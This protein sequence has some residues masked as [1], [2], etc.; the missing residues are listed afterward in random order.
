MVGKGRQG[1]GSSTD[2]SIYCAPSQL[3]DEKVTRSV[4]SDTCLECGNWGMARLLGV[5]LVTLLVLG[6]ALGTLS[7]LYW[8]AKRD[9]SAL[10]GDNEQLNRRMLESVSETKT[11]RYKKSLVESDLDKLHKD[12]T[13][14]DKKISE[15]THQGTDLGGQLVRAVSCKVQVQSGASQP[16]SLKLQINQIVP[17]VVAILAHRI[18]FYQTT[19]QTATNST[20][21][22]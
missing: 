10:Q 7:F 3:A 22:Y 12:L 11:F 21:R 9:L 2:Y 16:S 1:A 5:E 8:S 18:N 19:K 14:K 15:L 17:C 4:S 13:A 6:F 20:Y